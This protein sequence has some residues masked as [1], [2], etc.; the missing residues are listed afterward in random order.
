MCRWTASACCR[1]P[2]T[3]IHEDIKQPWWHYTSLPH[4][5]IV[6]FHQNMPCLLRVNIVCVCVRVCVFVCVRK[7]FFK[8]HFTFPPNRARSKYSVEEDLAILDYIREHRAYTIVG[9]RALWQ[10]MS[11]DF[12]SGKMNSII[13]AIC[14]W[15]CCTHNYRYLKKAHWEGL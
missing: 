5:L 11:A 2:H 15:S 3:P 8:I 1:F 10:D 12:S 14:D 13:L 9:G 4:S 6:D 7:R